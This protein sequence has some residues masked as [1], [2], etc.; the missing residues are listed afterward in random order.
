MARL[1]EIVVLLTALV[2]L[3]LCGC[4]S[5]QSPYRLNLLAPGIT[6]TNAEINDSFYIDIDIRDAPQVNLTGWSV[7]G[8]EDFRGYDSHF[9]FDNQ[10]LTAQGRLSELWWSYWGAR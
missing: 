6:E 7:P 9:K 8:I 1:Y 3:F 2:L 5:A 10:L 4:H